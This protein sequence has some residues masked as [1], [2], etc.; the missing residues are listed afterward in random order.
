VQSS[1]LVKCFD[2][3]SCTYLFGCVGLVGKDFHVL[4]RPYP[5]GEYF[6]LTNRLKKALGV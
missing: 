6:A 4:N 2:C 1:Y 3:T 5:R